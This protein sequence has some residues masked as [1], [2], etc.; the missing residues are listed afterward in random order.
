MKESGY[1]RERL[2]G[3]VGNKGIP[4]EGKAEKRIEKEIAKKTEKEPKKGSKT[5]RRNM[6][7]KSSTKRERN[8][9][10]NG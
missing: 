6:S 9:C 1:H 8:I 7:M 3:S 10:Q 4:K 2:Q 5:K